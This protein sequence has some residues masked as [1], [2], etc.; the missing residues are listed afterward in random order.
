MSLPY[1]ERCVPIPTDRDSANDVLT[2]EIAAGG[3]QFSA[4]KS[5]P[6]SQ[7]AFEALWEGDLWMI[8][9]NVNTSVL[10]WDSVS[11]STPTAA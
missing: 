10:H 8:Y 1:L 7:A 6:E 4:Q 3:T 9:R 2:L 5:S 11:N